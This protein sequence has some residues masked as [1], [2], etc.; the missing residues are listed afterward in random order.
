MIGQVRPAV[1][2]HVHGVVDNRR[3]DAHVAMHWKAIPLIPQ[4]LAVFKDGIGWVVHLRLGSFVEQQD[5][6]DAG[7]SRMRYGIGRPQSP[8]DLSV[9]SIRVVAK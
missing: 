3:D 8:S 9:L 7:A 5:I 1:T 2:R 4:K 6:A